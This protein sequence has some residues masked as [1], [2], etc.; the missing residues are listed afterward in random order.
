MP[1][2]KVIDSYIS[3]YTGVPVLVFEDGSTAY[4]MPGQT[5]P[6]VLTAAREYYAKDPRPKFG[7]V[8]DPQN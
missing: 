7:E 5:D 6:E 8:I 2:G 3:Q 1:R 4:D